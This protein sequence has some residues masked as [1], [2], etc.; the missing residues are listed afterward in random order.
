V[1][2]HEHVPTHLCKQAVANHETAATSP[3]REPRGSH[4]L[5]HACDCARVPGCTHMSAAATAAFH[6]SSN[7]QPQVRMVAAKQQKQLPQLLQARLLGGMAL[8]RAPTCVRR[9]SRRCVMSSLECACIYRP[10]D[11]SRQ[12]ADMIAQQPPKASPHNA[13]PATQPHATGRHIANPS[14]CAC[15]SDT[16]SAM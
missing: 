3:A 15:R 7:S 4:A 11:H 2:A 16:C 5:H 9:R 14:L 10:L 8:V 6:Y 1:G 12:P 13:T